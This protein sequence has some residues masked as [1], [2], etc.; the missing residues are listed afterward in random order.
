MQN[1]WRLEIEEMFIELK[2]KEQVNDN[3]IF[4]INFLGCNCKLFL[5]DNSAALLV[6]VLCC[7]FSHVINRNGLTVMAISILGFPVCISITSL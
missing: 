1:D 6:E 2:E 3:Y 5:V 4:E 7:N